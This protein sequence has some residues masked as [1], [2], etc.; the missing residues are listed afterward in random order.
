MLLPGNKERGE[1]FELPST[2]GIPDVTIPVAEVFGNVALQI[3][4]V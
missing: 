3:V 1:Q 2:K 4:S